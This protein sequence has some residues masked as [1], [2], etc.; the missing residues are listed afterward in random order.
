MRALCVVLL[1]AGLAAPAAASPV[2]TR[3]TDGCWDALSFQ[4]TVSA[5]DLVDVQDRRILAI[6]E[7]AL[8]DR[9]DAQVQVTV[10]AGTFNW[11][12]NHRFPDGF[13]ISP[14]VPRPFYAADR[15]RWYLWDAYD[16]T[17]TDGQGYPQ[18]YAYGVWS[19][20]ERVNVHAVVPSGKCREPRIPGHIRLND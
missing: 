1:W 10:E 5:A 9:P 14:H 15:G 8:L 17:V 2:R 11:P 16:V 7:P 3:S 6:P 18:V 20:G 12:T 4:F 13:A 19:I